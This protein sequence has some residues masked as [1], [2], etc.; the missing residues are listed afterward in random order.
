MYINVK[1]FGLVDTFAGEE[2]VRSSER[3]ISVLGGT[4]V[5]L[6]LE[7]RVHNR[8]TREI[9]AAAKKENTFLINLA[10]RTTQNDMSLVNRPHIGQWVHVDSFTD[11]E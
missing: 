1:P 9:I 10:S 2:H 11:D 6:P 7:A 8:H 5:E 4:T 3:D